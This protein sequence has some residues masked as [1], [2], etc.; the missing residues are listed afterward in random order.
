MKKL[1][2]LVL[3]CL[4]CMASAYAAEWREG[5]SPNKPSTHMEAVDFNTTLGYFVLW[6]S[7]KFSAMR[8]CDVLEIYLPRDDLALGEGKITLCD[9]DGEVA[10]MDCTDPVQVE[11]RPL[12]EIELE[13]HMWG[14]GSCLEVHL[15]ISMEFDK[16][17][18]VLMDE[19]CLY[20]PANGV[21]SLPLTDARQWNPLLTDDFGIGSLYYAKGTDPMEPQPEKPEFTYAP[22]EGDT[23]HFNLKLGGDAK[24][25]VVFSENDSVYFDPFQFTES[26]EVTGTIV[27]NDVDWGII[28]LDEAGEQLDMLMLK[29]SDYAYEEE[30]EEAAEEEVEEAA[31]EAA[32]E[33]PAAAN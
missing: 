12:E 3:V 26:G 27:S 19:G 31:E 8:M 14:C 32:E 11:L 16:S 1:I 28:F 30:A 20:D 7:Q 6:P 29:Q 21:K 2:A 23:V 24:E 9:E 17:Y 33:E 10:V 25:A 18:Y 22:V 15:P 13:D 4:L 5:L